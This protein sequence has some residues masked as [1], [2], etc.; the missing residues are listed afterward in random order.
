MRFGS[1]KRVGKFWMGYD[2]F[3]F[4]SRYFTVCKVPKG[5]PYPKNPQNALKALGA[6]SWKRTPYTLP[7]H[8]IAQQPSLMATGRKRME[9]M[10]TEEQRIL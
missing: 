10:Q 3:S 7:V 2:C 1:G 9:E 5:A 6:A 8:T 4:S